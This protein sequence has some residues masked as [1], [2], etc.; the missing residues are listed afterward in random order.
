MNSTSQYYIY[1]LPGKL[2]CPKSMNNI[3]FYN[4]I[5][6]YNIITSLKSKF[7]DKLIT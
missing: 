5:D 3:Y 1:G 6:L 7:S 2:G 4:D